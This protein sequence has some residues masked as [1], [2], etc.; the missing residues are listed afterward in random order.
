M[1]RLT[2]EDICK[3]CRT[4]DNEGGIPTC[5]KIT[6]N[7]KGEYIQ[8]KNP[9]EDKLIYDIRF[10]PDGTPRVTLDRLA[11]LVNADCEGRV[12]ISDFKLGDDVWCV[13]SQCLAGLL[14]GS[15]N[16]WCMRHDCESCV[17]DK[18][19]TVFPRK[20]TLDFVVMIM[21][22]TDSPFIPG[23]TMFKSKSEAQAALE[24]QGE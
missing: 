18:T 3:H 12:F 24:R 16:S 6:R 5:I 1:E 15:K 21:A 19:L 10:N 22:H 20:F 13:G 17:F 2:R 4:D 8:T 9:C 7:D 14:D 11:E 23:K